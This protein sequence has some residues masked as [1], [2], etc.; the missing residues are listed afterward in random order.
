M[1]REIRSET[2]HAEQVIESLAASY[3]D[4]LFEIDNIKSIRL[5]LK[6]I[7]RATPVIEMI[8]IYGPNGVNTGLLR[9]PDGE[10][11]L[12]PLSNDLASNLFAPG[13]VSCDRQATVGRALVINKVLFHN[14][15]ISL[16]RNGK[17]MGTV[18]ASIG[19]RSMNRIIVNLG[20]AN[21]TTA[22][23]LNAE[24]EVIAHSKNPNF[25]KDIPKAGLIDFPTLRCK[26][27][28]PPK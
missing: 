3:Q 13:Q 2:S 20:R 26:K 15:Y 27:L 7:L 17:T 6:F 21:D 12:D 25:F 22:F 5:R 8:H 28:L 19:R 1:E 16:A 11:I 10:M 18:V 24:N 9:R 4:G 14:I 23:V